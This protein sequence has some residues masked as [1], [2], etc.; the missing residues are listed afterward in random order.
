VEH[1]F[2]HFVSSKGFLRKGFFFE[3]KQQKTF[4][5][6]VT[7]SWRFLS[8]DDADYT[9][10]AGFDSVPATGMSQESRGYPASPGT[11]W[12][13]RRSDAKLPGIRSDS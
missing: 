1:D 3:K 4:I 11:T 12:K 10:W 2:G 9:R 7:G 13:G 8:A 6:L 5:K